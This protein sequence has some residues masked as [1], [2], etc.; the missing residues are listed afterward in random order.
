MNVKKQFEE[1]YAI[2]EENR[3]KKVATIMPQ[4]IELMSRKSNSSGMANTFLKDESGQV[5]AVYCYYHKKWEIVADVEY[6]S[7]ANT[8]TGLNTMCKEGVSNWTKQQRIKKVAEAD[9]LT[10]VTAGELAVENIGAE[11]EKIAEEAKV[12]VPREDGQG[13]EYL[14]E[15]EEVLAIRANEEL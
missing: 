5:V 14:E 10:K 2:L 8:A 11:R 13:Y 4:L 12:I 7:K 6:G 9:L 1:I 15:L 3:N